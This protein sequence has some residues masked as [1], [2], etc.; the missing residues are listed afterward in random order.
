MQSLRRSALRLA[1]RLNQSQIEVPWF[2]LT[3]N[4][5]SAS[6]TLGQGDLISESHPGFN[7]T[8]YQTRR[9]EIAEMAGDTI[10]TIDYTP[11]ETQ[12]WKHLYQK[13]RVG[14]QKM[15]VDLSE[16]EGLERDL[17]FHKG[18]PQITDINAYLKPL[19]GITL[20]PVRGLLSPRQFLNALAFK[21][22]FSTQYIR[23]HS[24]PDYTPEPDI[25]HEFLGHV[26]LFTKPE[27]ADFTQQLGL[28]S[29]GASDEEVKLLSTLYWFSLEFG[30]IQNSAGQ[31]KAYGAGLLSSIGEL[32]WACSDHISEE[33]LKNSGFQT[34]EF[35][36]PLFA[37]L[38]A[39]ETPNQAYPI[40]SYQ[41]LIY[42][43]SSF[44]EICQIFQE[45]F[46]SSSR[47]FSLIFDE[48]TQTVRSPGRTLV[49]TTG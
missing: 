26:P 33:C 3:M 23:H 44:K 16:F 18:I 25:C 49:R 21:V 15:A 32:E 30:I 27:V 4:E 35:K 1:E 43:A 24:H 13:L 19:T 41:P 7:D 12:T 40:T 38:S 5:L 48:D 17:E 6:I 45:F 37:K 29:L 14:H 47:G 11:C 9:N 10:H 46:E 31:R 2:P 28:A 34:S 8:T 20:R 36:K 22:F 42:H 39:T